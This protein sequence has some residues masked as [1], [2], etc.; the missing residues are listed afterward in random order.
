MATEGL[1]T[2]PTRRVCILGLDEPYQVGSRHHCGIV[3]G[4]P[5][6]TP[7]ATVHRPSQDGLLVWVSGCS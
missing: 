2:M 4:V 7:M 3:L 5:A 1:L 6:M